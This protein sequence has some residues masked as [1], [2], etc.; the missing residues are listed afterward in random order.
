M[1]RQLHRPK[2]NPARTMEYRYLEPSN[3]NPQILH[4][5]TNRNQGSIP[6]YNRRMSL[7]SDPASHL[8]TQT[9]PTSMAQ[10]RRDSQTLFFVTAPSQAQGS[11]TRRRDDGMSHMAPPK[12]ESHALVLYTT[13]SISPG[14]N[15]SQLESGSRAALPG[16][17]YGYSGP[18]QQRTGPSAVPWDGS[19]VASGPG[20]GGLNDL[21]LSTHQMQGSA[22]SRLRPGDYRDPHQV[23]P[24]STPQLDTHVYGNPIGGQNVFDNAFGRPYWPSSSHDNEDKFADPDLGQRSRGEQQMAPW[25]LD[26]VPKLPYQRPAQAEPLSQTAPG[27]YVRSFGAQPSNEDYA[28]QTQPRPLFSDQVPHRQHG[29]ALSTLNPSGIRQR[30]PNQK[31][32]TNTAE[33]GR[34]LALHESRPDLSSLPIAPGSK[35]EP[36]PSTLTGPSTTVATAIPI[37]SSV[38]DSHDGNTQG[39]SAGQGRFVCQHSGCTKRFE[40]RYSLTV[41]F[42]THT[43][44]MPYACKVAGCSQRFKWRSS[45][46]HHLRTRHRGVLIEKAPGKRTGGNGK[47]RRVDGAASS[48]GSDG[49]GVTGVS[50]DRA[51]HHSMAVDGSKRSRDESSKAEAVPTKRLRESGMLSKDP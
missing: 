34:V 14:A 9:V 3:P 32:K 24:E 49:G 50:G 46:S 6:G 20:P 45:Q 30:H 33:P 7:P 19:N 31:T 40:R 23:A 38:H 12:R 8:P 1:D 4:T 18:E 48:N 27:Q 29:T 10:S 11:P 35:Q 44:E 37:A 39:D 26:P 51:G 17:Y 42:R 13:L 43:N 28:L 15:T 2:P 36:I 47:G 22:Y 21:Q 25:T 16:N 41:H 5:N